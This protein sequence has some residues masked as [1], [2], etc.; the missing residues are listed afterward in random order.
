MIKNLTCFCFISFLSLTTC[1]VNANTEE[2]NSV[3]QLTIFVPGSVSGGYDH[4]ATALRNVLINSGLV[5][6]IEIIHLV[7]AGGVIALTHFVNNDF[8]EKFASNICVIFVH[9]LS[10]FSLFFL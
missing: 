7:G 5:K 9:F 1:L 6:D 4:T 3:S 10:Y 2:N 8:S